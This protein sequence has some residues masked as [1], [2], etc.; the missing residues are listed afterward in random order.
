MV[1]RMKS[2]T[3]FYLGYLPTATKVEEINTRMTKSVTPTSKAAAINLSS[4]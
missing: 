1:A 2:S 3:V 4:W